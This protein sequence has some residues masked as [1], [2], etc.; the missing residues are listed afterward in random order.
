MSFQEDEAWFENNRAY[1]AQQYQ[2]QYVIVLGKSIRGSYP[3]L[4]AAFNAAV[5]Q[6][7]P[8]AG[9][10]IKQAIAG[11]PVEKFGSWSG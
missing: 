1:I 2:G 10:V 6:F 8:H 11:Q 4:G 5:Q 7:G 9:F 3:T